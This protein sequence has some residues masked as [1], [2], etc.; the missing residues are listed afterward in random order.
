[1]LPVCA[2]VLS[3]IQLFA[4]PW[5]KACQIPLSIGFSR[6]R[7][8]ELVAIPFSR[9]SFRPRDGTSSS[10]DSCIDWQVDSLPLSHL[11]FLPTYKH[12]HTHPPPLSTSHNTR[13]HVSIYE[14][15][16]THHYH[17]KPMVSS[18]AHFCCTFS[19]FGQMYNI[20]YPPL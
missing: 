18:R 2:C 11:E 13:L 3:R 16:L 9:G 8:L 5:T 6:Q 15:T 20:L 17:Q 12:T 1:M 19:G 10:C 7:I 14:P 4:T